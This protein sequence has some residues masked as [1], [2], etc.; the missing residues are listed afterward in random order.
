MI[1]CVLCLMIVV[2]VFSE[3]ICVCMCFRTTFPR[4][5]IVKIE[6]DN[7]GLNPTIIVKGIRQRLNALPFGK[8]KLPVA[9]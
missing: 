3:L 5:E 1:E 6:Q 9:R 7:N 4:V 8:F 2:I